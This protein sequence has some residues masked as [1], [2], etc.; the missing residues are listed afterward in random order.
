M[1]VRVWVQAPV[2]VDSPVEIQIQIQIQILDS[3]VKILHPRAL[4]SSPTRGA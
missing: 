2:L 3:P 4:G 1:Q